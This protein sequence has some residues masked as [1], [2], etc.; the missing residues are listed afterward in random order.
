MNEVNKQFLASSY[1]RFALI[2]FHCPF[3]LDSSIPDV[4]VQLL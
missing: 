2:V 1:T 4:F 3:Y